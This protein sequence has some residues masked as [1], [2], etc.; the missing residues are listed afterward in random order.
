MK[1]TNLNKKAF[2]QAVMGDIPTEQFE[3]DIK[4]AVQSVAISMCP[5]EIQKIW[6]N[7]SLRGFL[8]TCTARVGAW[9]GHADQLR[10]QFVSWSGEESRDEKHLL[11]HPDIK[12]LATK[13]EAQAQ[14]LHDVKAK[15]ISAINS[16]NTVKQAKEL[17][18]EFIAYLPDEAQAPSKYAPAVIANLSADLIKLGWPKD[19]VKQILT[20]KETA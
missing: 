19:K 9:S 11:A 10:V 16:V 7:N 5:P 15:L 20:T 14:N 12:T 13:R 8:K 6:K 3:D 18:P 1:L 17:F 2:V 4:T